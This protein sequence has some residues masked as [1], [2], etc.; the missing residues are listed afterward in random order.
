MGIRDQEK[1]IQSEIT[2]NQE[3][4]EQEEA[5]TSVKGTEFRGLGGQLPVESG[6]RRSE[7]TTAH[8]K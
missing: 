4:I 6:H 7:P 3:I 2:K 5:E 8:G 1:E